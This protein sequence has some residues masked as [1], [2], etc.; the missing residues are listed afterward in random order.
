MALL[1]FKKCPNVCVCAKFVV[2]LQRKIN[3]IW[4]GRLLL[5]VLHASKSQKNSINN[6]N[7]NS[8]FNTHKQYEK[9]FIHGIGTADGGG[10]A[11]TD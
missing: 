1:F 9:V 8:R 4:D 5:F 2:S 11:S 7:T 10:N 3:L 6:P